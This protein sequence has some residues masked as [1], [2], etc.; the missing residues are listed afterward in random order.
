MPLTLEEAAVRQGSY[1]APLVPHRRPL[2]R[3]RHRRRY[4]AASFW[5]P[6]AEMIGTERACTPWSLRSILDGSQLL[7]LRLLDGNWDDADLELAWTSRLTRRL[8]SSLPPLSPPPL[9]LP[10]LRTPTPLLSN[11]A[12]DVHER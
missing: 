11:P 8:R 4:Y 6:A 9:Q 1:Y 5:R 12:V 7:L 3:R 10:P 2:A